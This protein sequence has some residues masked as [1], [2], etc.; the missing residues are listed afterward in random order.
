MDAMSLKVLPTDLRLYQG[1]LFLVWD[2]CFDLNGP[3]CQGEEDG[4]LSS[5]SIV[6]GWIP[7]AGSSNFFCQMFLSKGFRLTHAVNWCICQVSCFLP[8]FLVSL[9]LP[10]CKV[11]SYFPCP[12]ISSLFMP[13][14]ALQHWLLWPHI[15]L[16]TWLYINSSGTPLRS[17]NKSRVW[18]HIV[19][20][21]AFS[22]NAGEVTHQP[23][24]W[25]SI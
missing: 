12:K 11:K 18:Q 9:T 13:P 3:S 23:F 15:W 17:W 22:I 24:Q 16:G 14:C 2:L 8:S 4:V 1:H 19:N 25:S 6:Q 10:L 7:V 5:C 21:T 20:H